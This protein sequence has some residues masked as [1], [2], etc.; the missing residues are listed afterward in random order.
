MGR[1]GSLGALPAA[2]H[3]PVWGRLKGGLVPWEYVP[4]RV[5]RL[6]LLR[7][8]FRPR[9]LRRT[10]RALRASA[11]GSPLLHS[12]HPDWLQALL[13]PSLP[14]PSHSNLRPHLPPPHTGSGPRS[15]SRDQML[16]MRPACSG[17]LLLSHGALV[18][19][20]HRVID[21]PCGSGLGGEGPGEPQTPPHSPHAR[22]TP[23][24][25]HTHPSSLPR[26]PLGHLTHIPPAP[27]YTTATYYCLP[28][29]LTFLMWLKDHMP[30][31]LGA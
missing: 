21:Q 28:D 30:Q 26:Q 19:Q 3:C 14:Q 24:R 15:S 27:T 20:H 11:L 2:S 13:A 5:H 8:A 1:G 23:W 22:P 6:Q 18:L 7:E 17:C 4:L 12:H 31:E 9:R 29:S 16:W 10:H 25:L